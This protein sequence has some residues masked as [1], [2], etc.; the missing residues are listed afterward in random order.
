MSKVKTVQTFKHT[1]WLDFSKYIRLRDCLKTTGTPY[2]GKCITCG[3]TFSFI[4][5]Q[6]GHFIGG[7]HPSNL[8]SEKG[9]NAQCTRCNKWLYGNPLEYRRK[10]IE[11]YGEGADVELE[12]EAARSKKFTMEELERIRA[13]IKEKIKKLEKK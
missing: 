12:L 8:F 4:Q 6:A 9:V 5:L 1:V 10:I 11:M 7:R 3:K 13:E 2:Y